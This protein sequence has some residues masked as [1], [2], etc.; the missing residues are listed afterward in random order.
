[1]R[2][3]AVEAFRAGNAPR[4]YALLQAHSLHIPNDEI[5]TVTNSY[6][7]DKRRVVPRYGYNFA[8]GLVVKKSGNVTDL[9]PIGTDLSALGGTTGAGGR[10]GPPRSGGPGFGAGNATASSIPV[11]PA[12]EL[13]DAAGKY[14]TKFVDAF[15]REHSDGRW[16]E[17]FREYDYGSGGSS[18]GS[19]GGFL[20]SFGGAP[21]SPGSA[22]PGGGRPGLGSAGGPPAG[23]GG[24]GPPAGYN[25]GGGGAPAGYGGGQGGPPA[26]YR[27]GGGGAPPG[28]GGGQGGPPADYRGGGSGAPPGYGGGQ[29]GPPADY[30]GGGSGAPPGYGT[31]PGGGPPGGSQPAGN[32]GSGNASGGSTPGS[33]DYIA[34][35]QDDAISPTL[36]APGQL[37]GTPPPGT[38]G[39]APAGNGFVPPSLSGA[40]P[41]D[42]RL[43]SGSIPLGP[44]LVYIGSGDSMG[45]LA[46]K[47]IE[48][49]FDALVLF[50]VD[51]TFV[52]ANGTTKND[53]R[54]RVVNLHAEKDSK[55]KSIT[56]TSLNARDVASDKNP[57][58]KIDTA[59]DGFI[60]KMIE[61]YP[62]EDLPNIP[63]EAI[64]NKRLA[65]L[66]KDTSRTK[67]DL[68]GEVQLYFG[69]GLID[70]TIRLEAFGQ[71]AGPDG[72]V[73]AAGSE[74][75]KLAVLEKMIRREFD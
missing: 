20:S 73:L 32:K 31:A 8:V 27:G 70:E 65:N 36:G 45:E 29:G 18:G 57:D 1:M 41:A 50:E 72:R 47:A 74:D 49:H 25:G 39:N 13:S 55:D 66:A 17:A 69:K 11:L 14:A 16:S 28:Y 30:K 21:N 6:R 4:A 51:V 48:Q 54:I 26:D 61:A 67:L 34:P 71:I 37:P 33:L 52:R 7:W 15:R 46:K 42:L 44:G 12:K 62:M 24:G 75:E 58:S 9:K 59:V 19:A 35:Y 53:C 60:K 63:A 40:N 56:S 68:L 38:F 64:K 43:P 3:R 2:D 10:G 22:P 23:Y 5:E